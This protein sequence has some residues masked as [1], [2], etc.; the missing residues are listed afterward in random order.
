MNYTICKKCY[1]YNGASV[2]LM[3]R[4]YFGSC[5][6]ILMGSVYRSARSKPNPFRNI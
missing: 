5:A 6:M 2:L 3:T 1:W 4:V